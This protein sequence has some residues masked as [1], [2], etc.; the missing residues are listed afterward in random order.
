VGAEKGI[1]IVVMLT[2]DI[3]SR[4]FLIES[5]LTFLA[6][7]RRN[8]HVVDLKEPYRL[9]RPASECE[10]LAYGGTA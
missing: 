5:V 4:V 7:L 3:A 1:E 9:L 8:Q 6:A 2:I 10:N